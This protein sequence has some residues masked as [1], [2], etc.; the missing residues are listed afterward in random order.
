VDRI[1]AM[2]DDP[3]PLVRRQVVHMLAD[4]SPRHRVLE[5]VAVLEEMRGDKDR[6]VRRQVNRALTSYHRTGR[7]NVL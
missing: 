2:A 5:V 1:I 6:V 3:S 4:G 7:V